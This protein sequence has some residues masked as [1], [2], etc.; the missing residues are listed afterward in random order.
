MLRLAVTLA[1]LIN[2]G[3]ANAAEPP[4]DLRRPL[5]AGEQYWHAPDVCSLA[6]QDS[7]PTPATFQQV[8]VHMIWPTAG[9]EADEALHN[10]LSEQFK[11]D[12]TSARE[13]EEREHRESRDWAIALVQFDAQNLFGATV[14]TVAR[15]FMTPLYGIGRP[16]VD[17]AE[18]PAPN[19]CRIRSLC[20]GQ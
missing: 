15:C 3:A 13:T 10:Y 18:L 20:G 8:K 17:V 1:A 4:Q 14:R 9:R 16:R 6:V 7:I 2:V 19:R 11:G 5:A 12:F